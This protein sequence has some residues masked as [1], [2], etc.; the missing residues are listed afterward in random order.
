[1][2]GAGE[3][4]SPLNEGEQETWGLLHCL[5]WGLH[6]SGTESVQCPASKNQEPRKPP[7]PP[8]L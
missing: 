7:E 8:S 1:M 6:V 4:K 3:K 2:D 5:K